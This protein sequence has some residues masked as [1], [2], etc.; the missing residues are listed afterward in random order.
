MFVKNSRYLCRTIV[1]IC[2]CMRPHDLSA[3]PAADAAALD[4]QAK[5]LVSKFN[6]DFARDGLDEKYFQVNTQHQPFISEAETGLVTRLTS[7][8][9][10]VFAEIMTRMEMRGDFDVEAEFDSLRLSGEGSSGIMLTV[11]LNDEHKNICRAVHTRGRNGKHRAAASISALKEG[12]RTYVTTDSMILEKLSGRMR[13]ARRGA[14]VSYLVSPNDETEFQLIGKQTL[15]NANTTPLAVRL[16]AQAREGGVSM[17]NWRSV[18]IRAEQL[19][20]HPPEH[21]QH[22]LAV[23]NT[24]GSDFRVLTAPPEGFTH[25]GSPEWSSDGTRI[26]FDASL[27]GTNTSHIFIMNSDGGGLT[28]LG[29][30]TMPS[31]ANHDES[32]V[33]TETGFGVIQMDD[34]GGGRFQIE[35]NGRGV[36]AAPDGSR[37][38]WAERNNLVLL[39]LESDER[40]NIF[41]TGQAAVYRQITWNFAWSPDSQSIAFKSIKRSTSKDQLTV[42]DVNAPKEVKVLFAR[43]GLNPDVSWHPDGKR[44]L[45]SCRALKENVLQLYQISADGNSDAELLPGQP[46]GLRIYDCDWSPDGNRIV[47][48]G[49][50]PGEP[51]DWQVRGFADE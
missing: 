43:T 51:V 25:V 7:S 47:L 2:V 31:F 50:I 22:R 38:A 23:M 44:I 48:S 20:Y 41:T 8:D 1:L 17:V 15:T 19:F 33:F 14:V 32:I 3:Q 9:K 4:D 11:E 35:E 39:D 10:Y 13:I 46:K 12:N 28:D 30:G 49:I 36:Q 29:P 27:D 45:F 5:K 42:V 16:R 24:D 40:K 34:D 21:Q 26:V 37:I 18:S 6:Y